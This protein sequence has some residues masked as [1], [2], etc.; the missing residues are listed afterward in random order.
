M[1]RPILVGHS[2]GASIAIVYA[3]S[4]RGE[5]AGLILEAPHVLVEDVTVANIRNARARYETTDLKQRLARH[6]AHVD[7]MF[8]TW[9]GAWLRPEFREWT[10]EEY[11][12]TIPC[13]ALVI[14]GE[15]DE[16]GTL[17]QV[18]AVIRGLRGTS[19]AVILPDCGH[20]PHVDQRAAV[21]EAMTQFIRRVLANK[22]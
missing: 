15:D 17:K 21:E 12:P 9:T 11:R 20:A 13:R 22:T 8:E 1:K 18:D 3:G 5:V 7:S 16:Y 10:I 14:Q 6:H 4:D 19:E 2:D